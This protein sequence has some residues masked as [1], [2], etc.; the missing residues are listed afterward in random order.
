MQCP[1]CG[2]ESVKETVTF[3]YEEDDRYIF[4]EHFPADVCARWGDKMYGPELPDELLRIAW[5]E[6]KHARKIE[7]P[8]YE[9]RLINEDI[10]R[11]TLR[12]PSYLSR[13]V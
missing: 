12:M 2:G 7:V 4:V 8:V 3:T 6:L 11:G 9:F 10:T 13:G 5:K 1:F